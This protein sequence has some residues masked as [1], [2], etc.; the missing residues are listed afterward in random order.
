M[1]PTDFF[2][3]F[4]TA[5]LELKAK[6]NFLYNAQESLYSESQT[7]DVL[8]VMVVEAAEVQYERTV[9]WLHPTKRRQGT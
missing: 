9:E 3:N 5:L 6:Q 1:K 2:N 4:L 8:C 7:A